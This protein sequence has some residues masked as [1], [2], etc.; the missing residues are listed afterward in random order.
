MYLVETTVAKTKTF[1]DSSQLIVAK[2]PKVPCPCSGHN[3]SGGKLVTFFNLIC[4]LWQST[5]DGRSLPF[6][7]HNIL[8]MTA[9]RTVLL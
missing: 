9:V 8:S 1:A 7:G 3:S 4:I 6:R 2:V 5:V